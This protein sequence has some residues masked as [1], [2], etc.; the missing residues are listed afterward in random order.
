MNACFYYHPEA[1]TTSNAWGMDALTEV[2]WL[3][4]LGVLKVY[5]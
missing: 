5:V 3:A 2:P 4:K 1:Y